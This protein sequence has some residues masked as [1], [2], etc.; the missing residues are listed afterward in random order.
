M[1]TELAHRQPEPGVV[2]VNRAVAEL[3]TWAESARAAHDVAVQL[4]QT[5]F[6]PQSF[7]DKPHEATAAILSGLEVGLSP[8]AA[9][10]SY[11]VISGTAAPRAATLRAIL[12]SRG[13]R[14]WVH[15]ATATRAIVRGQRAGESQIQESVWTMDRAKQL[16][17]AGKDNWRKQPQ[18]MLVARATAECARLVASDAILGIAYTVEEL[19]DDAA[20]DVGPQTA[21]KTATRRT[22]RRA[23]VEPKAHEP[24]PEPELDEPGTPAAEP[25]P[26][27]SAYTPEGNR[28]AGDDLAITKPQLTKLHIQLQEYGITD[29]GA[30]LAYY[31]DTIGHD[32]ESSKNLTR[33]EASR[34]IDRLEKELAAPAEPELD[35]PTTEEGWQG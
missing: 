2:D 6:V 16:G 30:G 3:A 28:P 26:K 10:R 14:I 4:C 21:T 7:R 12:Q 13:H 25:E 33:D 31:A 15:E 27:P 32:V 18:A 24:A 11:D 9:L 34:I 23:P 19:V 22:A 20:I 5:S 17:L 35:D 29:R 8:M 1:S